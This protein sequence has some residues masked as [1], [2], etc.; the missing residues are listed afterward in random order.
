MATASST[1]PNPG[2]AAAAAIDGDRT[3]VNWGAGGG[4]N[5]ATRSV[6]PD[7]LEVNFGG[8]KSVSIVRVVTLQN[9]YGSALDPTATTAA[10][11]YGLRDFDVEF[12]DGSGWRLV[13][14]GQVRSNDLA[15]RTL[16]FPEVTTDR[17]RVVV[18]A[19]REHFSRVVELEAIGCSQ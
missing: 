4:W 19:A 3:G 16:I 1:Y 6:F 18:R 15:L 17:V 8:Q 5:D 14:G 13:P 9:D 12:W 2:Y 7:W 10:T 11:V